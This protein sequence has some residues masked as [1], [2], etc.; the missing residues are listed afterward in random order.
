MITQ[1]ADDI[2]HWAPWQ[3]EYRFG[4]ILL[5][6]PDPPASAVN[7]L[8][9][10]YDPR[11]HSYCA[12]HISLTVPVP[13]PLTSADWMELQRIVAH[14]APIHVRY[15]PLR[16]YLPAPGVCLAIEPRAEL[17]HLRGMLEDAAAFET[18]PA[19][20]WPFSAHM[21]IAEFVTQEQTLALMDEIESVAPS[22]S[23]VC[24]A[25]SYAVPDGDFRFSDRGRLTLGCT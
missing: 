25:V 5:Y 14:I 3:R 21:T 4:A 20:R 19:R 22:G 23:F 8:R 10:R 1:Y 24:D 7:A 17:D 16:H 2:T 11:S 12:A 6:P 13:R 9:A 18:A 15:G